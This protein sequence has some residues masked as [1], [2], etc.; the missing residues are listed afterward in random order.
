MS[1]KYIREYVYKRGKMI[2]IK[3]CILNV[4]VVVSALI[5]NAFRFMNLS[6]SL[7]AMFFL[8]EFY[9]SKSAAMFS[10]LN[11]FALT[12]NFMF[13]FGVFKTC[14]QLLDR[15]FT[16]R[17]YTI[18]NDE[19]IQYAK[20]RRTNY[21]YTI[22]TRD[23]KTITTDKE[24]IENDDYLIIYDEDFTPVKIIPSDCVEYV[25]ERCYEI[26]QTHKE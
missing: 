8:M 4:C 14:A 12:F 10:L 9:T 18:K 1:L 21:E 20:I 17:F 25:E 7:T 26:A 13:A 6:L 19:V 22:H 2:Y 11:F 24:I 16:K 5:K 23:D 15:R 3:C